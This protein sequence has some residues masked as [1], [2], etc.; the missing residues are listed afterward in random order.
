MAQFVCEICGA[1]F[2]QKSRYDRHMLTSHPKR[3]VSAADLEKAL[4]GIDFPKRHD[5][6]IDAVRGEEREVRDIVE[7]LPE[8]QY[9]DAAEVARAFG[10]LRTHEKAPAN[11]PSKTGGER[12]K[13]Q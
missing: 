10:E 9:R 3:A 11:Q 4:Q 1:T 6:L 8:R 2:E 7:R 12:S 5:E 13:R